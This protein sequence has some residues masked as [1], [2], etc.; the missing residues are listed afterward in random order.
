MP[1]LN[2]ELSFNLRFK[3][4]DIHIWNQKSIFLPA[5]CAFGYVNVIIA[6]KLPLEL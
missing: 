3:E 6:T 1:N 2:H 5:N 4:K